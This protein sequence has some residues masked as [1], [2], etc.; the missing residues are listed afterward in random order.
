MVLITEE[1]TEPATA[2]TSPDPTTATSPATTA[3]RPT[4]GMDRS[5]P[6]KAATAA[7][8]G[9]QSS[10]ATDGQLCAPRIPKIAHQPKPS[11]PPTA[12]KAATDRGVRRL[13]LAEVRTAYR[14]AA[15]AAIA[16]AT[17]RKIEL[18]AFPL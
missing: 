8:T 18:T 15:P 17:A 16:V 6:A 13:R 9:T 14:V 10:I 5:I 11:P 2:N 3:H 4:W 12:Q 7:T 1:E